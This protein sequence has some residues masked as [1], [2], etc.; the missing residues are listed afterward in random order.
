M[1][2]FL[3]VAAVQFQPTIYWD[4]SWDWD[5]VREGVHSS[6]AKSLDSLRGY[7]LDLIVLSEAISCLGQTVEMAESVKK[8]GPFL[9]LYLNFARKEKLHLVGASKIRDGGK[10][11]NS[12]VVVGPKGILGCY[13]K[14]FPVTEEMEQGVAAGAG[15]VVIETPIARIG[16]A[17]CFDLNFKELRDEY[18]ALRPE[19]IAFPSMFHGGLVQGIWAYE[20]RFHFI[21]SSCFEDCGILDPLGR[22]VALASDYTRVPMAR[23]NLDYVMVH[24][25][26][27]GARMPDIKRKYREEV[28]LDVPEHVGPVLIF[29]NSPART[30]RDIAKEFELELLDD[31][32]ARCRS[33]VAQNRTAPAAQRVARKVQ[34]ERSWT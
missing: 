20:C 32:L 24:L 21:S 3:N 31:Y 26:Q 7:G 2:R 10:V 14:N 1:A 34:Q 30:A 11:Y 19:I 6:I 22:P 13:Y 12:A 5:R 16:A 28:T 27:L 8:P 25:A 15:A 4:S 29:S 18:A 23:I 33:A 9:Q 17:I